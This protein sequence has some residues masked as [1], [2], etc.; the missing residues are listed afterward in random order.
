[1]TE[2]KTFVF[3]Q[4]RFIYTDELDGGA[5]YHANLFV[6][7]LKKIGRGFSKC[8]EMFSGVGITGLSLVLE[9]ICDR[10]DLVDIN[11]KCKDY[12]LYNIK[13]ASLESRARFIIS[14]LFKDVGDNDYD[15]II[16]NP[17]RVPDPSRV[18]PSK[19]LKAVDVDYNI[20]KEFL[21]HLSEHL[22]PRGF[23]LLLEDYI[24][25]PLGRL[26]DIANNFKNYRYEIVKPSFLDSFRAASIAFLGRGAFLASPKT[27]L[28][29]ISEA[30]R[31]RKN[32]YFIKI[33][34][35]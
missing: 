30:A 35:I 14:D 10:V 20:H 12:A 5:S 21:R 31:W 13:A 22:S 18:E 15:L 6:P 34:I 19:R 16:G 9:G 4:G 3:K 32:F 23:A 24:N 17:P 29:M 11:P 8:M 28:L 2:I 1:M 27:A 7:E 33:E 25:L 26:R